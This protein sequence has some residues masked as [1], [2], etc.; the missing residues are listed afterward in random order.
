MLCLGPL[1]LSVEWCCRLD[2]T[3]SNSLIIPGVP[4]VR[5]VGLATLGSDGHWALK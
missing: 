2:V 1:V 5:N 3:E 4:A